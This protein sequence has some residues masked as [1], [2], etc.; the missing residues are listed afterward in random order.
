[1]DDQAFGGSGGKVLRY[2]GFVE[3]V[4]F[5][6]VF[7]V[8]ADAAGGAIR[9]GKAVADGIGGGSGFAFGRD[10]PLGFAPVGTS[11]ATLASGGHGVYLRAG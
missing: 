3:Q 8:E 2:E 7:V 10:R 1:V 4:E 11:G 9:R 5:G 6:G